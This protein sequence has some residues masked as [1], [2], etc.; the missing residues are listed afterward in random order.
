MRR[1]WLL[2]LAPVGMEHAREASYQ[3]EKKRKK[4][5]M[6]VQLVDALGDR[7]FTIY[8]MTYAGHGEETFFKL[9]QNAF[10]AKRYRIQC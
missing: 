5:S 10:G 6:E 9:M 7:V 4:P 8:T 3:R 2:L 1:T